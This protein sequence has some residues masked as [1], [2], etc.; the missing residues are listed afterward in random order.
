MLE[1]TESAMGLLK[2]VR[3]DSNL[4]ESTALRIQ[5][6]DSPEQDE[7][8]IGFTFT[9]GPQ[10]QDQTITEQ[11][12]LRVYVAPELATPLSE[13]VLDTVDTPGGTE[14]QLR[15]EGSGHEGH[16]HTGHNHNGHDHP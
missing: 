8:D 2:Q 1:I 7:A 5:A 13:A 16:D 9:S 15:V 11:P 3:A 10:S 12:D 4:P 6:V 14:L